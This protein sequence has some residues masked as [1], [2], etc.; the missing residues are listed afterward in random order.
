MAML[1]D[2]SIIINIPAPT[3]SAGIKAVNAA[4]CGMKINPKAAKIDP[5]KK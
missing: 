1:N 4:D 5:S 2:A 3:Q